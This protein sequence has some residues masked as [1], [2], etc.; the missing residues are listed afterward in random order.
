MEYKLFPRGKIMTILLNAGEN[1]RHNKKTDWGIGKI[2]KVEKGGTVR[3]VF[4]GHKDV[5]IA[6]GSKYLTKIS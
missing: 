1:V 5:S 2:I 4:E 6:K 3:V